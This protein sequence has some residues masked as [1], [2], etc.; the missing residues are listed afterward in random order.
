[1]AV[2]IRRG[3]VGT[4][5]VFGDLCRIHGSQ[6]PAGPPAS[7]Q[8]FCPAGRVQIEDPE[9]Q[10][11]AAAAADFRVAG[12]RAG[13]QLYVGQHDVVDEG[14]DLREQA[15]ELADLGRRDLR[16]TATRHEHRRTGHAAAEDRAHLMRQP[17]NGQ[18]LDVVV[19]E[20]AG[21]RAAQHVAGDVL[22]LPRRHGQGAGVDIVR[23]R[24]V[25][26]VQ[27]VRLK[28]IR[29]QDQ[30]PQDPAVVYRSDAKR[31]FQRQRSRHTVRDRTHAANPLRVVRR[32]ARITALEDPLKSAEHGP[33]TAGGNDTAACF[34][35]HLNVQ[36][37]LDA[38][39]RTN[40]N[41]RH[42]ELFLS[43][44]NLNWGSFSSRSPQGQR[45]PPPGTS[46][47]PTFQSSSSSSSPSSPSA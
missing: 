1:M 10:Q 28:E 23:Q 44:S 4:A 34:H 38:G 41:R 13:Q 45:R 36:M 40:F 12:E 18:R 27:H 42:H 14:V 16:R 7:P 26:E 24:Q 46:D 39:Q 20:I 21:G 33:G 47:R 29:P 31:R 15:A 9:R 5:H 22:R 32:V 3:I 37:A 35:R 11:I 6:S 2:T 25:I 17:A 43:H 19:H 30:I 8:Q